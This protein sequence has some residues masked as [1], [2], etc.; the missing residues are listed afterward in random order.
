MQVWEHTR[1]K[2][3]YIIVGEANNRSPDKKGE[4]VIVYRPL[5]ESDME[6]FVREKS[7]FMSK[8]KPVKICEGHHVRELEK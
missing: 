2:N 1:D 4:T 8:F 3:Y 7:D 5:Y 6:L